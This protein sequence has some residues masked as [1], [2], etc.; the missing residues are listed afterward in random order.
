MGSTLIDMDAEISQLLLASENNNDG[1]FQYN[2]NETNV[3]GIGINT[4]DIE[5]NND[6]SYTDDI[7][8]I[9]E[10]EFTFINSSLIL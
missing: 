2:H 5:F 4:V 6:I 3:M 10:C 9:N 7:T 8:E 1:Q